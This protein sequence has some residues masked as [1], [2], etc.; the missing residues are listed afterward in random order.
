V[1]ANRTIAAIDGPSLNRKR[2]AAR[3]FGGRP[4]KLGRVITPPNAIIIGSEPEAPVSML[5]AAP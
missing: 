5:R 2:T 3:H 4:L 1:P